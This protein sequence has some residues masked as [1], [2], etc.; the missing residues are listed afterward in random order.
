[1]S[2]GIMNFMNIILTASKRQELELAYKT[3]KD[4]RTANKVNSILLLDDGYS[5][6]EV[7]SILRLDQSTV[8]R[9]ANSYIKFGVTEFVK[10]PFKGRLCKLNDEQLQDLDKYVQANLCTA[11][12]EI[13]EYANSRYNVEYTRSGMTYLLKR[14]DFVYKKPVLIPEEPDP[15]I[16]EAFIDYY[17][18]IIRSMGPKDKIY[19]LDGVHPQHNTV[20]AC[21]WIKKGQEQQLQSNTGRQRVNLNGALDPQNLEVIVRE[22]DTL[23]SESTI[24][25]FKM[26]EERNPDDCKIALIAD[27]ARYYYNGD[28]VDYINSSKKL[29]MIHLPPYC[30]NLNLIE[31]VWKFM[32]KKVLHNKYYASFASFK[33]AIGDFFQQLPTYEDLEDLI[34][35][36]FQIIRPCLSG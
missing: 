30:P 17:N 23:N 35:E 14:L 27:N 5:S 34:S 12:D 4:K 21:G 6:E 36:D 15:E 10:N 24:T 9:L 20:A 2:S 26:I 29:E 1:M 31:R 32:K 22:D 11:T 33:T 8:G 28:V 13:V 16:Q 25:L 18:Q 7:A 3:A 19:F